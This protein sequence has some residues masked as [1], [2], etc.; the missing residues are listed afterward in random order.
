MWWLI[1]SACGEPCVPVVSALDPLARLST[2]PFTVDL[3]IDRGEALDVESHGTALCAAP[4]G[5]VYVTWL[6]D[7]ARPGHQDL[8]LQRSVGPTT[9]HYMNEATWLT[10]P[11]PV[12]TP[13]GDVHA[14]RLACSVAGAFVVWSEDDADQVLA[15]A[16]LAP[17]LAV[18]GLDVDVVWAADGALTTVSSADAGETWSAP[19]PVTSPDAVLDGEFDA[20]RLSAGLGVAWEDARDGASALYFGRP[21]QPEVR[22]ASGERPEACADGDHVTIVWTEGADVRASTSADGGASWL[23]DPLVLGSGRFPRCAAAGSTAH[24]VWTDGPDV[25]YRAVVGG[26]LPDEALT[27]DHGDGD[28][29]SPAIARD[30]DAVA[31]LWTDTRNATAPNRGLSDLLYTF[32]APGTS[33]ADREDDLRVDSMWAGA[34]Y[35]IDVALAVLG[36][37]LLATWVDGRNGTGDVYFTTLELGEASR[38]PEWRLC[39]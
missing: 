19:T 5:T 10:L 31:V 21:G 16:G 8:W 32:A 38:P 15:P 18:D 39:Q 29:L 2:P 36:E 23:P 20:V 25:R 27:L 28:A 26:A 24:V 30:G 33:F 13:Q 11:Q 17:E 37:R 6:D 35:K 22:V 1:L 3:R 14:P 34:S 9:E 12:N 7:R 4:D